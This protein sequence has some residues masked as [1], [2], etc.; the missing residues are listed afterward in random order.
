MRVRFGRNDTE[1]VGVHYIQGGYFG[2]ELSY[3]CV[4]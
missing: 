4:L 3:R 2:K 1:T